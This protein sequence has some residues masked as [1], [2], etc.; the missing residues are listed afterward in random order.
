MVQGSRQEVTHKQVIDKILNK[1]AEAEQPLPSYLELFHQ[2]INVQNQSNIPDLSQSLANLKEKAPQSLGKKKP[3]LS[4]GDLVIDW[5][6]T[7]DLLQKIVG[8]TKEYLSPTLEETAEL[9]RICTD[10]ALTNDTSKE[11]FE[12]GTASNKG[13]KSSDMS[14]L[15]ASVLQ[16][17][18]YPLLTT[19][20]S[21]LS[22]MIKQELW[23][24]RYCP[25]CGGSPDFAFLDKERGARW[26]LCS[27]CDAQ[28]LYHRLVCPYCSNDEQ[29]TLA[30][31]TDDKGLY[32]LYVCDKCHHYIKAIDTR[33]SEA[34]ILFPLER[35]LTLDMDR[36]AQE[37][38]YQAVVYPQ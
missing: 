16:A 32:R 4:F 7:Q 35:V 21:E 13:K 22:P 14:P 27:R 38:K 28:W 5:T 18:F 33:K 36:Q 8:L 24:Q 6:E 9:D 11:W 17:T 26:L 34:E 30:F 29:K 31:F 15:T 19:Y 20:S 2:I 12:S 10:R 37:M 3:I 23:Y 25:V 1:M